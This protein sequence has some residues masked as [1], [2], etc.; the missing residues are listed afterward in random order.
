MHPC[1][2]N[3]RCRPVTFA[4]SINFTCQCMPGYTGAKCESRLNGCGQKLSGITGRLTY[5]QGSL[6]DHNTQCA[7]VIA[8]NES[9]VLN[10]TFQSFD[11]EDSTE[12]RFDWLQ[13]NDG[14]T[15]ASQIIGRFCGNHKPLGGNIVTTTNY[16]YLWFRSDNS[17]SKAGFDLEWNSVTPQCGGTINVLSHGTISSPGSP[18]KYPLNRDCRWKLKAPAERRIKITFFSLN[19]EAHETCNYDYVEVS[20]KIKV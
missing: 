14:R 7:W 12:C 16:L 17:T 15:A 2:N 13:L 9:L 4:S 8:T 19:I 3:G 6:Y 20:N 11:L 1:Q 5:P 18:G 10:V